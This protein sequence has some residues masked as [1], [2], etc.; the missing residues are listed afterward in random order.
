MSAY[1]TRKAICDP[2]LIELTVQ[3]WADKLLEK[4]WRCKVAVRKPRET[5]EHK[6]TETPNFLRLQA[7]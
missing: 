6:P 7:E 4:Q 5:P 1:E 2:R 3:P